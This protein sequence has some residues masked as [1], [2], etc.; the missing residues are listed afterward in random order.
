MLDGVTADSEL[1]GP[2]TD[3]PA[4][5]DPATGRFMARQRRVVAVALG[6]GVLLL[7]VGAVGLIAAFGGRLNGVGAVLIGIGGGVAAVAALVSLG[8]GV[9]AF[10]AYRRGYGRL[11]GTT[12]QELKVVVLPEDAEAR[13]LRTVAD[14]LDGQWRLVVAKPTAAARDE[15]TRAGRLWYAGELA[16]AAAPLVWLPAAGGW[17][18]HTATVLRRPDGSDR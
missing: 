7:L 6:L 2:A 15:L 13:S 14:T 10:A 3:G 4:I 8:F 1:A 17:P 5:G 12:W 11:A 9:V 16:D 18:V